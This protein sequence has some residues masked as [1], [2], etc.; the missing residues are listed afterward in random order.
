MGPRMREDKGF[1][2]RAGLKPASTNDMI[3]N[4]GV[5]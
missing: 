4:V 2:A 1:G 3:G 5:N